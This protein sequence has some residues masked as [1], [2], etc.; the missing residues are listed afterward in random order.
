MT[1]LTAA[2]AV[3]LLSHSTTLA[4]SL[5][6]YDRAETKRLGGYTYPILATI[7]GDPVWEEVDDPWVF[8]DTT[9]IRA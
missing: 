8:V 3:L 5:F 2:A 7:S 4:Y 9:N 6:Q 1:R